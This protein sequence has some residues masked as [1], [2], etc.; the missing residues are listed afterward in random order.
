MAATLIVGLVAEGLVACDQLLDRRC[1]PTRA[2][3]I[4]EVQTVV[5]EPGMDLV[6]NSGDQMQQEL[7]RDGRGGLRVQLGEG[8][9]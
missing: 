1:R 6:G 8:K 2:P 3:G 9:L 4:G 7:S 5:G